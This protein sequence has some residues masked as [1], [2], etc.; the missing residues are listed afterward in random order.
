VK[1]ASQ[2]SQKKAKKR[3]LKIKKQTVKDLDA[4]KE[5]QQ[6]RGGGLCLLSCHPITN[7]TG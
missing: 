3:D 2:K 5:G 6:I 1:K 4:E 7:R